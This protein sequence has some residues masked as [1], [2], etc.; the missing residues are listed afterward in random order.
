MTLIGKLGGAAVP[1]PSTSESDKSARTS[2]HF[3]DGLGSAVVA[4]RV[5]AG[6]RL[7]SQGHGYS[8]VWVSS[9]LAALPGTLNFI[10][11]IEQGYVVSPVWVRSWTVTLLFLANR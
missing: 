3:L 4:L 1:V 6:Q 7:V 5:G 10:V 9:C 8:S 2:I 11:H